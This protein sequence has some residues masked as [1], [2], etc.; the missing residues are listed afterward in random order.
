MQPIVVGV[1]G[2][3]ASKAALRWAVDMAERLG[4]R[5]EVVRAWHYPPPYHEWDAQPSGHGF[6]SLPPDRDQVERMARDELAETAVEVLGVEPT[7]QFEQRVING[8][9]ADV[10]V[11]ASTGAALLVVGQRGHN[12]LQTLLLGSVARACTER[13]HCPVVVIPAAPDQPTSRPS[14][15]PATPVTGVIKK[16]ASHPIVVGVDGSVSALHAVRWAAQEAALRRIP[17]RLVHSV[18]LSAD[19]HLGSVEALEAQGRQYVAQALAAVRQTYPEVTVDVEVD[20]GDPV[21]VLVAW[22]QHARLMAV[23]C[24][25][26]EKLRGILTGSTAVALARHGHCPL[27]VIRG[28]VPEQAAARQGP[29]VVGV[30]GSPTS[31]AAVALAF[32]EASLHNLD[33]VAVHTWID[34]SSDYSYAYARQFVMNWDRIETE[35]RELLA[36]LLAGWRE[37]YPD[38]SVQQVVTRDRPV[39]HLLEQAT[40]AQLLVLGS[41]GHG[42][43]SG[44]VLGTTSQAL[45]YHTP[46]PL[47]IARPIP[48]P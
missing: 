10:L 8:H 1:D 12:R 38:V 42:A 19:K 45:I 3:A 27:A 41:R 39:R 13:A 30:D 44:M 31:E 5:L 24:R 18:P 14:D 15:Q 28:P 21:P 40:H 29:V 16:I 33:L 6:L 17:L 25:G 35:E 46:C 20:S 34:F 37:K 26:L 2:S 32:E 11:E 4:T 7:V 43:L 9:P 22:S 23:G 47:L 48:T 36:Q